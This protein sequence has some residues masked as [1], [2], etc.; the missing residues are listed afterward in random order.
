MKTVDKKLTP[1]VWIPLV[2]ACAVFLACLDSDAQVVAAA[3]GV[4][5]SGRELPAGAGPS[6]LEYII[7]A[8]DVL[9]LYIMDVPELSRQYRVGADGSVSL[10]SLK[11]PLMATGLTITAFSQQVTRELRSAGL[12]TNPQVSVS[13]VQSRL[14]AVAITGAVNRPQIY[15][16]FAKTTLLDVL[17]QAEG[18][19]ND[20]STTAVVQRGDLATRVLNL[21][22]DEAA[23]SLSVELKQVLESGNIATNID[24]Y[25]GDRITVPRAGIVYVVGAVNRP[26]GFPIPSS[27]KGMSVLQAIA[28]AE[29]VKGSAVRDNAVIIRSDAQAPDGRI[30]IPVNLKELLAGKAP[31]PLL[32]ADDILFIPDS[33][34][35]RALR[36][37]LEAILQTATG[38]A[39]YH[40]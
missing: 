13:V 2:L 22:S 33:P 12:V 24:I 21:G 37:G 9:D 27:K 32:Q 15:P 36:R 18:L 23:R 4:P 25:P 20:A 3:K 34:G 26:G 6:D 7:T 39:I 10:P 40:H 19:A 31:D 29:D 14:H 35:K 1:W 17:S 16:V 11:K 28:F 8:D 38:V 5:A 30:Q